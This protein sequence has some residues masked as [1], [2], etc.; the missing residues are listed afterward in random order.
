MLPIETS[1]KTNDNE[2]DESEDDNEEVD[3][4]DYIKGI[5]AMRDR[6]FET[7]KKNISEAQIRQKKDYDKKRGIKK[8]KE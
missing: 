8:V 7:A 2:D 6:M 1:L 3:L 5:V 4:Q